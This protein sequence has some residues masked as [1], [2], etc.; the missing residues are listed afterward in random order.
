MALPNLDI[1]ERLAI[2]MPQRATWDPLDFSYPLYLDVAASN[3]RKNLV[4]A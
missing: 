3:R 4:P 1:E 2:K